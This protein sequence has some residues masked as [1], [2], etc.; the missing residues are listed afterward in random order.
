M[1]IIFYNTFGIG[2][3]FFLKPFLK[4]LCDANPQ[5]QFF[6]FT[7]HA[8][9]FYKDIPNLA[10]FEPDEL[11]H[12]DPK[13][14][15]IFRFFHEYREQPI[16][17][18]NESILLVNTWV[19]MWNTYI[20]PHDCECCPQHMYLAFPKW[21]DHINS[22]LEVKLQI[23]TLEKSQFL[24]SMPQ[25]NL[26]TF[27]N[28]KKSVGKEII[29]YFNRVGA[30]APTKPFAKEQDHVYILER[31]AKMYPNKIILVPNLRLFLPLDN[32]IP[33]AMFDSRESN[34]CE[35]V[36]YDTE[37]AGYCDYAIHFDIGA[38]LTYCNSHFP[39]YTAKFF[40]CSKSP[41]YMNLVKESLEHCI[42]ALTSNL[43]YVPCSTPDEFLQEIQTR[44]V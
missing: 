30:S 17:K 5:N 38:S 14:L 41:R 7:Q 8:S 1:N 39:N 34:R 35:N 31:L 21:I 44:I 23:P 12:H 26:E 13:R 24:Y 25:M 40:H 11:P 28:F 32:I 15:S 3:V 22:F 18:F 33:T 10:Q 37:L 43:T 16:V 27:L 29:Y 36:L 42:H 6:I 2:D 9:F 20:A 19:T 4:A